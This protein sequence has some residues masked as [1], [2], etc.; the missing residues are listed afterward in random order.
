[1][2]VKVWSSSSAAAF[3]LPGSRVDVLHT[4]RDGSDRATSKTLL[5]KVPVLAV[6]GPSDGPADTTITTL[7][8]PKEAVERL[9]KAE[10]AAS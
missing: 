5:Q 8:I 1:V 2:A 4:V 6:D 10:R 9:R 3:V 7:A